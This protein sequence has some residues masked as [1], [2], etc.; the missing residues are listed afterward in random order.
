MLVERQKFQYAPLK[1]TKHL[2]LDTVDPGYAEAGIGVCVVPV[3]GE[4]PVV[5]SAGESDTAECYAVL[6][7]LTGDAAVV[8]GEVEVRTTQARVERKPGH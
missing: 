5:D 7:A 6:V 2:I 8:L 4:L 3:D 1:L